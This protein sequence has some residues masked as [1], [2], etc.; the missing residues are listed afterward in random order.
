MTL[1]QIEISDNV[2]GSHWS[3]KVDGQEISDRLSG[4]EGLHIDLAVNTVPVIKVG[5]MCTLV[6]KFSGVL[7]VRDVDRDALVALGWTPPER[8][9]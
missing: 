9:R 3:V 7:E 6:A 8:Q 5:L 1:Q 4:T 2:D